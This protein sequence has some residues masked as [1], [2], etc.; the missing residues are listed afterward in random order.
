M[1][2]HAVGARIHLARSL[3]VFTIS[4]AQQ[5]RYPLPANFVLSNEAIDTECNN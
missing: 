3:S 4:A 5:A 2:R 1:L